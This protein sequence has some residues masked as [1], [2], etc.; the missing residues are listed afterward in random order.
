MFMVRQLFSGRFSIFRPPL[1]FSGN[2]FKTSLTS[3][4]IDPSHP[5]PKP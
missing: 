3:G 5:N 1:A 4:Q 2:W